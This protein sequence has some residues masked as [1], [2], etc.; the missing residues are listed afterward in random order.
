MSFV[1]PVTTM[2][3]VPTMQGQY[4]CCRMGFRSLSFPWKPHWRIFVI[5]VKEKLYKR[6]QNRLQF[7]NQ[8]CFVGPSYLSERPMVVPGTSNSFMLLF[9]FA[10]VSNLWPNQQKPAS[11][12][13]AFQA[14]ILYCK[15]V[16]MLVTVL[17]SSFKNLSQPFLCN[18]FARRRRSTAVWNPATVS[19]RPC[20]I[21]FIYSY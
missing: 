9:M 20:L 13:K 19:L 1:T 4:I 15:G 18:S 21:Y 6:V 5:T 11:Q 10:V 16:L 12:F 17:T 7:K 14:V 2:F 8:L 3:V